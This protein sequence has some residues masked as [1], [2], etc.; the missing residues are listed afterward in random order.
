MPFLCLLLVTLLPIGALADVADSAPN[1]FTVVNETV[2]AAEP[3]AAFVIATQHVGQW[4]DSN[5]TVSG[6]ASR[7]TIEPRPQGCFCEKLGADAG[8]VH[9]TVTFVNPGTLLRMT[10]GL[11][12]LGLMGVDGNMLWEFE[13]VEGGTRVTWTYAVGGYA[14]D[15]LDTLAPSVD[16]VLNSALQRF[17]NFTETGDPQQA[18]E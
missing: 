2:V 16:Y 17:K 7:M 18:F 1:G 12:P 14:A 9:L 3:D 11:G 10:G 15:G 13:A 5:H 8:L 6:D 4:W